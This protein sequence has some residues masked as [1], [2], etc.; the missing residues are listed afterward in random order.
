MSFGDRSGA[1]LNTFES[2]DLVDG[3]T[4]RLR[5]HWVRFYIGLIALVSLK[6]ANRE[7]VPAYVVEV[8]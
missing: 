6:L 4:R 3:T 7:S 2:S 1:K 5:I 8:A